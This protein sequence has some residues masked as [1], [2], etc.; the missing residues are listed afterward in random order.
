MDQEQRYRGRRHARNAP[1]LRERRRARGLQL[2]AHLVRQSV[3]R[4]VVEIARQGGILVAA[5]AVDL[6]LLP[7]DIAGILGLDLHLLGN[8]GAHAGITADR[9]DVAVRHFRSLQQVD[10]PVF[11]TQNTFA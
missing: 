6:L 7:V 8:V 5:H 2:V 9:D 1:G 3:D 11:T 10:Q 4:G